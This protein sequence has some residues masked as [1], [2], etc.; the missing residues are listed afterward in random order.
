MADLNKADTVTIKQVQD[1]V[2]ESKIPCDCQWR[3]NNNRVTLK[4]SQ[5]QHY[6]HDGGWSV[7]GFAEK[8]WVYIHC[9]QCGYDWALHKLLIR[10]KTHNL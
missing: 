8:Q 10:A 6:N 1:W 9:H 2:D 7:E 4:G 5:L 3:H